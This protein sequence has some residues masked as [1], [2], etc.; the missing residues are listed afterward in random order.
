MKSL[1]S[2]AFQIARS[3]L[4]L[5]YFYHVLELMLHEVL[6]EEAPRAMPMTG[7]LGLQTALCSYQVFLIVPMYC[8]PRDVCDFVTSVS[9]VA[10]QSVIA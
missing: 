3:C 9:I 8:M 1:G 2:H 7:R 4:H 6:E 10:S 5:P